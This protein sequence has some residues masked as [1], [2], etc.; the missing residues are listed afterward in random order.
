MIQE[1]TAIPLCV[2]P[3]SYQVWDIAALIL[4]P[5]SPFG[6]VRRHFVGICAIIS[7]LPDCQ[8]AGDP[9]LTMEAGKRLD[10]S[11][12]V[13]PTRECPLTTSL[14][15]RKGNIAHDSK[16]LIWG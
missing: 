5:V 8:R 4:V 12:L 10:N 7:Q 14:Q 15:I 6:V 13:L 9:P 2:G 16:S 3:K 11:R 1:Y